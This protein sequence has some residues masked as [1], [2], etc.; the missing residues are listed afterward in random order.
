MHPAAWWAWAAGVIALAGASVAPAVLV[1]LAAVTLTV[2]LVARRRG[3]PLVG[4]Y[5][6]LALGVVLVRVAFHVL[7]GLPG[8]GPVLL[9]L[10]GWRL[11]L[12]GGIV[13]LGPLTWGGLRG[14]ALGGLQLAVMVLAAGAA[15]T[16]APPTRLLGV[17]P[18]ALHHVATAVVIAVGVVPS[19]AASAAAV[20]R[21]RRLRGLPDRGVRA[22]AQ[23]ALPVLADALDRSLT[24]AASMD[25]RGFARLHGP[26]DRRVVPLLVASLVTGGLGLYGLL[27][28]LG[29]LAAAGLGAGVLLGV[30]AARVAGRRAARTRYA[31]EP[32]RAPE[33]AMCAVGAVAAVG[34]YLGAPGLVL[35]A[36]ACLG[37]LALALPR[38]RTAALA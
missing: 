13:V 36:V 16:A 12:G 15:A 28:G 30:L 11:P 20:R 19:L 23:T 9:A 4:G 32:W 7:V 17:L 6:V 37:A 5:L 24:L 27:G 25:V 34:A 38:G 1:L 33:W 18:A 10:P 31:A 2:L 3:G 26:A 35:A 29:G 22:V 8:A 14:A 21:A